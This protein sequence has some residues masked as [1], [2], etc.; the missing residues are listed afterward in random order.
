MSLQ[1]TVSQQETVVRKSR[2]CARRHNCVLASNCP[3]YFNKY[4]GFFACFFTVR[5]NCISVCTL[6][7]V[8]EF[9][10]E[11]LEE[12]DYGRSVDW[13]GYGVCLYEMMV[14]RLPFYDMDH[15][16]LFQ[17][18]VYEEVTS[19]LLEHLSLYLQ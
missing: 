19:S 2:N 18:I 8:Y 15:E 9:L 12:S 6:A 14:G 13:W 11:V 3:I 7:L 10:C 17:L 1:E 4:N 16:Q 5:I